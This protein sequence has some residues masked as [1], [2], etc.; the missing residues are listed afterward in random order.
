MDADA[1]LRMIEE[2]AGASMDALMGW[3]RK[4]A[5]EASKKCREIRDELEG[6][7]L[8]G[9]AEAIDSYDP[10]PRE[11]H[12]RPPRFKAFARRIVFGRV[13]DEMRRWIRRGGGREG[14]AEEMAK[15]WPGPRLTPSSDPGVLAEDGVSRMSRQPPTGEGPGKWNWMRGPLGDSADR[16]LDRPHRSGEELSDLREAAEATLAMLP[17]RQASVLRA[18]YLDGLGRAGAR[19]KLGLTHDAL[20]YAIKSARRTLGP[21]ERAAILGDDAGACRPHDDHI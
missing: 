20:E 14:L 21:R 1:K 5:R 3:S 17:E 15:H 2:D 7:A 12:D 19:E 10:T 18:V 13:I 16:V 9:L 11:G 6:A 8:L 4:I